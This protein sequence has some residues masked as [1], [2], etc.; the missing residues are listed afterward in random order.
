M[1]NWVTD[2]EIAQEMLRGATGEIQGFL[3]LEQTRHFQSLNQ[4]FLH[5]SADVDSILDIGCGAADFGRLYNFFDYMGADQPHIIEEVAKK[6]NPHLQFMTFDAYNTDFDFVS[7]Y[8]LVLMNAFISEIAEA[9]II[10]KKILQKAH[11]YV[12]IHRQKIEPL[13]EEVQYRNYTGY[14]DKTYTCAILSEEFFNKT[15]N[16][17]N[18]KLEIKIPSETPGEFTMLLRKEDK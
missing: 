5:A 16:V 12:L 11:K 7:Q 10:F 9:N 1:N 17:N 2:P 3:P 15:L 4:T 8:D 13:T 18:F 6:K 14:L